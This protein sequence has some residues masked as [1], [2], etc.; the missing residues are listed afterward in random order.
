MQLYYM[1]IFKLLSIK[2]VC[3][4]F[5]VQHHVVQHSESQIAIINLS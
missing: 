4:I 3:V 1:H 2:F 5:C